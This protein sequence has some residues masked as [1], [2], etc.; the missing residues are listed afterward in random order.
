MATHE[1]TIQII[2]TAERHMDA[3]ERMVKAFANMIAGKLRAYDVDGYTLKA[4]KNE[5]QDFDATRKQWKP[6]KDQA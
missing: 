6:R 1:E 3:T 4:L 2:S 5:L